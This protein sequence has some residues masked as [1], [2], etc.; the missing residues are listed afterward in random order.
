MGQEIFIVRTPVYECGP[1]ELSC[2][3]ARSIY[4]SQFVK[5]PSDHNKV[6]GFRMY[7]LGSYLISG[8]GGGD[9]VT[10]GERLREGIREIAYILSHN[11]STHSEVS[12]SHNGTT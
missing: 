9:I 2:E 12:S 5:Q 1:T 10:R 8:E 3:L 11:K 4:L 7:V 6:S